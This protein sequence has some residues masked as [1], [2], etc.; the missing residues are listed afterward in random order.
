MRNEPVPADELKAIQN[1]MAGVFTLQNG[2]R[3]GVIGQLAFKDLQGLG[4]D[5]LSGYVKRVLS[6]SSQDVQ[7]IAQTY[8][9]PNKMTMVVVGDKKTVEEQLAPWATVVP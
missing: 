8:L 9:V 7:R 1:N 2:S 3:A 6:I 4:D 5:Y